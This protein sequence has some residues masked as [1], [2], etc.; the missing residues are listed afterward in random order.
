MLSNYIFYIYHVFDNDD[1]RLFAKVCLSNFDCFLCSC[2]EGTF[3]KRSLCYL[4]LE[5]VFVWRRVGHSLFDSKTC[6]CF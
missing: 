4:A 3:L 1:D 6:R 2:S 5:V